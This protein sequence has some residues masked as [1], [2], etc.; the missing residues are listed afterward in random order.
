M[1]VPQ[2]TYDLGEVYD[3]DTIHIAWMTG[4]CDYCEGPTTFYVSKDGV[5][6]D[7]LGTGDG[8]GHIWTFKTFYNVES[9]RYIKISCPETYVDNSKLCLKGLEPHRRRFC[10]P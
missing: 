1:Y 9:V 3:I 4:W 10:V 2:H 5:D 6:W 8:V 7:V